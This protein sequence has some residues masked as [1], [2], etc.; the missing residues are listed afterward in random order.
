MERNFVPATEAY[1]KLKFADGMNL[2]VYLFGVSGYGKTTLVEKYLGS[3]KAI[4]LSAHDLQ[5]D[6]S[7]LEERKKIKRILVV[8]DL[9]FLTSK[10][11]QK[12][13][14]SY[15]KREDIW[16]ILIGR[17][18]TPQWLFEAVDCSLVVVSEK[19]LSFS[20]KE[21]EKAAKNMEI[22]LSEREMNLLIENTMGS[23]YGIMVA[24][25]Y[26]KNGESLTDELFSR[27]MKL[28]AQHLENNIISQ[29][30]LA[31][32]DFLMKVSVVNEFTLELAEIITGDDQVLVMIERAFSMGNFM[33]KDGDIYSMREQILPALRSRALKLLGTR[34][35]NQCAY[36]AGLYYEIKGQIIEALRMYKKCEETERIKNLLVLN[37]RRH[38][39]V[40][41]YYELKEYY[42]ALN[43]EEVEKSPILMSALSMLYSILMNVE[44]SEYWYEKLKE[45]ENNRK[46]EEKKEVRARL[47]YLDVALPHR[48]SS[49]F[50]DLLKNVSILAQKDGLGLPE[51]SVT[52][53]Q[54]SI[55]N[56]GKDFCQWTKKDE[57]VA[58]T[59]GKMIQSLVGEFG[60]GLVS[61]ALAESFYEKGKE[62]YAVV[63]QIA[64]AQIEAEGG[65]K[66]EI[67]FVAVGLQVR[68]SLLNGDTRN[69]LELSEGIERRAHREKAYAL[70]PNTKAL[71]CRIALYQ[72]EEDV[73]TH[74]MEE[75]PDEMMEF[76]TLERYRYLTKVRC[77][78]HLGKVNQA[79]LLLEK[80]RYYADIS[81]RT[82]IRMETNLFT[83][84]ARYRL[85]D[86]WKENFLMVLNEVA[87]YGFV[88]IIS[89][90]GAAIL[91]LLKKVKREYLD[92]KGADKK[93]FIKVLEETEQMANRYPG[94]LV[95]GTVNIADFSKDAIAILRMQASG[96]TINEIAEKMGIAPRTV[97][98]HA[99]ENYKKLGVKGKTD[100]LQKARGMNL[101]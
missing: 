65:G 8:D 47:L 98:Y 38:P 28:Y 76:C 67:L 44:K 13:L 97:K 56:G 62:A 91:P 50:L 41:H 89:E 81:Q 53:N 72:L 49:N 18:K 85:G 52:N 33:Q 92:M 30:S 51:F 80:L 17:T 63:S 57:F 4:W 1:K 24:L 88:R 15:A 45:L 19:E 86:N 3:R 95:S 32:Q 42:M 84:I 26:I 93:W 11:S 75:A 58:A 61:I 69:A 77:Y 35:Y 99:A 27:L 21:V 66:I 87:E 82:Y 31:L 14:I 39:G 101:L 37:A 54:P 7:Q 46:G 94:Y 23:P 60:R 100:A 64:K 2:P 68:L 6:L 5:W 55:I 40:G 12:K 59:A 10:E 78:L 16:L 20:I 34:E 73:I 43:E 90:E 83:A 22:S 25:Q 48:G 74:W 71:R 96:M 79:V 29:W 70:L 9:H 36:N